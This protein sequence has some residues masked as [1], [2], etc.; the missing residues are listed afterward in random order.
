MYGI[1][2]FYRLSKWFELIVFPNIALI[3]PAGKVSF[4]RIVNA[5][6]TGLVLIAIALLITGVPLM[7]AEIASMCPGRFMPLYELTELYTATGRTGEART[8]AQQIVNK[9]V[10]ISSATIHAIKQKMQELIDREEGINI[11]ASESRT[12]VE[13]INKTQPGQGHLLE[14][15]TPKELL[16]P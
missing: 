8:L 7:K 15:E 16:P 2:T 6:R 1:D 10:K 12:D 4:H 5:K 11:P 9:K 14:K 13:P 3:C